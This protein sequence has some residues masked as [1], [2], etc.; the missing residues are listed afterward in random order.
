MHKIIVEPWNPVENNPFPDHDER[1]TAYFDEEWKEGQPLGI[2]GT[3][4]QAI[5]SLLTGE[6]KTCGISFLGTEPSPVDSD[7]ALG[8]ILWAN[9]DY[10]NLEIEVKRAKG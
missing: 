7:G 5:G 2:G 1:W 9:A 8:G 10:F 6:Y 4:N 3:P